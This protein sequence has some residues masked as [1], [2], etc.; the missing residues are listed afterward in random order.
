MTFAQK[1]NLIFDFLFTMWSV[2]FIFAPLVFVFVLLYKNKSEANKENK[3]NEATDDQYIKMVNGKLDLI[4]TMLGCNV[5]DEYILR[6]FKTTR[7]ILKDMSDK[8]D[9]I[10]CGPMDRE[11]LDELKAEREEANVQSKE[12]T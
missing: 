3:E 8:I 9:V 1:M 2:V 10:L 12:R 7:E 4:L 6:P 11:T 5:Y